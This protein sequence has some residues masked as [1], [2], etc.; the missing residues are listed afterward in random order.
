MRGALAAL[1]LG[2]VTGCAAAPRAPGSD[3]PYID[4]RVN[5][6]RVTYRHMNAQI[7]TDAVAR[8][9]VKYCREQ[10]REAFFVARIAYSPSQVLSQFDCRKP[11]SSGA[12]SP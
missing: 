11:A 3:Q 12:K 10:G 7:V 5:G 1:A 8:E 2:F 4:R 6:D 9:A